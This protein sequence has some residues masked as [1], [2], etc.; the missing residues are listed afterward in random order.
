M[1][2]LLTINSRW[3]NLLNYKKINMPNA[4]PYYPKLSYLI[5]L[6]KIPESLSFMQNISQQLFDKIYYKDYQVSISPPLRKVS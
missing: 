4:L 5:T 2:M 1:E 3:N 6:D